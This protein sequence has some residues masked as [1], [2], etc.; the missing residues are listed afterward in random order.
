MLPQQTLADEPL[1]TLWTGMRSHPSVLPLVDPVGG[2]V[3]E[4]GLAHG[5]GHG[6]VGQT[7]VVDVGPG[8]GPAGATCYGLS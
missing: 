6:Q 5:A 1:P 7:E 4:D 2:G 3:G 8:G